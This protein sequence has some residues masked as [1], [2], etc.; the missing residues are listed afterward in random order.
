MS[1]SDTSIELAKKRLENLSL[2]SLKEDAL[3]YGIKLST[4]VHGRWV[5]AIID[6]LTRK[7]SLRSNNVQ[8]PDTDGEPCSPELASGNTKI[9]STPEVLLFDTG[10]QKPT[11]VKSNMQLNPLIAEQLYVQRE[12][13]SHQMKIFEQM[14]QQQAMMQQLFTS[15]SI[16]QGFQRNQSYFNGNMGSAITQDPESQQ[17]HHS[18]DISIAATSQAIKFLSSQIPNFGG[19]EDEDVEAWIEK[20]ESVAEIHNLSPVVML[21]AATSKVTKIARRWLE[22]NTGEVNRSWGSFKLSLT[23]LKEKFFFILSCKK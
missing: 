20:I 1:I 9:D 12:Q 3:K 10:T 5:D 21:A 6:Y 16:N 22:L 15:L 19:T 11:T 23:I 13:M 17:I 14:A 18:Q 2:P 8:F 7:G 4:E